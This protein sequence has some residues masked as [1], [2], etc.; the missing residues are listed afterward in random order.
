MAAGI[1]FSS[2]RDRLILLLD[3]YDLQTLL[4]DLVDAMAIHEDV[5]AS[6]LLLRRRLTNLSLAG[7]SSTVELGVVGP[8]HPQVLARLSR[9]LSPLDVLTLGAGT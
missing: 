5:S 6:S 9:F 4:V 1:I 7:H 8:I 2:L 3:Q